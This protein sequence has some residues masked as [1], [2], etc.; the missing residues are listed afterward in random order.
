MTDAIVKNIASQIMSRRTVLNNENLVL[1][2]S[3]EV[4]GQCEISTAYH[5]D[6]WLLK[7]VIRAVGP[8]IAT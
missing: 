1:G 7:M 8:A 3:P 6:F 2:A 5:T 4:I